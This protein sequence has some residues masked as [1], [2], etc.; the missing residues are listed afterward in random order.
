VSLADKL[1]AGPPAVNAR[2]DRVT[3]PKGWEPGVIYEPSGAQRHCIATSEP[4]PTSE[5]EAYLLE[6]VGFSPDEWMISGEIATA[7]DPAA[8]HRD[9]QKED[10]VT[11]PVTRYK[12]R[13]TVR[14]AALAGE[15]VDAL[16]VAVPKRKPR[17]TPAATGRAA[18][19]VNLAD[20]QVGKDDG[21]GVTGT[22]QRLDDMVGQVEDQ[23][24]NLRKIGV[25][26]STLYFCG[27]GDL[28]E[29]CS[30]H[31]AQ[32]AFRTQLNYRDQRKVIRWAIDNALDR[33]A[34]MVSELGVFAVGGNHGEARQNGKSYTDFADNTDVAVFEDVAFAY[35][36]N[37]DRYGH[38]SFRLPNDDLTLTFEHEGTVIGLAHGHQAGFG[39]GDA[40][41]KIAKWWTGQSMGNLP[42][43]DADILV[44]GHYHHP[45][46][47][48]LGP[49]THFGCPAL[50]GGSDW[51]RNTSGMDSPPGVLTFVVTSAGW[52]HMQILNA[53]GGFGAREAA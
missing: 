22:I 49:R 29:G 39:S 32:Q 15:D 34:R 31:Y 11:R 30:Q 13:V 23:W 16:L 44:T 4:P 48:P 10:A 43:G 5:M 42:I 28:G 2:K 47:V 36:K 33:W 18:L 6:L 26:L 50:D 51:F 14:V 52:S 24:R 41:Q 38:V 21:D 53:T 25:P 12:F 35:S 46:M 9:G 8:W 3:H 45:W 17:A 7:Y 40:R 37:P 1:N 27:V 19:V 20:S